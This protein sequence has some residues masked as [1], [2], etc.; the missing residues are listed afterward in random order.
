ML[1]FVTPGV[2]GDG[3]CFLS[4]M[5]DAIGVPSAHFR[6]SF[7]HSYED[8]PRSVPPIFLI[9]HTF[10]LRLPNCVDVPVVTSMKNADDIVSFFVMFHQNAGE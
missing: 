3:I 10:P 2:D 1:I 7:T 9:L 6:T 5:F 4:E 8:N